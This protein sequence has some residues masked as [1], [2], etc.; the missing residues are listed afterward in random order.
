MDTQI[1]KQKG[2]KRKHIIYMIAAV[3]I[4]LVIAWF[5]F[6]KHTSCISVNKEELTIQTATQGLFNDYVRINGQ[7]L[8]IRTVQLSAAEGGM[9]AEKVVE[10]GATVVQGEVL[11]RLTNPMLH[12]SILDSEAQLA[13]KQNFLRNTLLDMEQN[14][15]NLRKEQLQLDM[16]VER[17]KRK[18]EQLA[19]LYAEKLIS[20]EDY[21]QARE[22]YELASN[23]RYLV[24]ERQL[25][26][27]IFRSVQVNQLEE[28]LDN[29]RRNLVLVRQRGEDLNVKAPVSGQ[30]GLLDVEIGQSVTTGM[31]IGQI[32]VLCDFKVEASIDEHY[33]DRVREGL[34]ATFER[35]DKNFA[36]RVR[37]V[38]PEVRDQQF[39][40]EFIFVGERPDNIRAGQTY[41]INLELGQPSEAILIP[42]GSFY[43]ST[44]GQWIFVLNPDGKRAVRRNVQIKRQNPAYYEVVSG[45]EPGEKVIISGYERFGDA[46]EVIFKE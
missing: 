9:V 38:Y 37:K 35:Q 32:N 26:D 2:L 10:E 8:P 5:I 45:L 21:L 18:S 23:S 16:E 3:L 7:V 12:L 31:R 20:Q 34:D 30:L 44:G 15:L 11:I 13:E 24:I 22:D 43:Q 1:E 41:Y 33:I 4:L 28:S 40:T 14:R 25:Q 42:R 19:R 6:G 46:D 29:M 39:K 27:S 17:K 36:L